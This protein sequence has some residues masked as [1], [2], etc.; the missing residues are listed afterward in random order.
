MLELCLRTPPPRRVDLEHDL[1]LLEAPQEAQLGACEGG[2][3]PRGWPSHQHWPPLLDSKRRAR[4]GR[5]AC[6]DPRRPRW[7]GATLHLSRYRRALERLG[8]PSARARGQARRPGLPLPRSPAGALH[9]F[10]GHP[11][12]RRRRPA[13]LLRVRRRGTLSAHGQQQDDDGH[14]A[15]EAL[16][17]GAPNPRTPPRVA[18]RDRRRP[19]GIRSPSQGGR[20]GLRDGREPPDRDRPAVD[21]RGD[22]ERPALH[23]GHHRAAEGRAPRAFERSRPV[24]DDQG[25]AGPPG[26]R[27]LLVHR[28]PRLGHGHVL[29]DHRPVDAGSDTTRRRRRLLRGTLVQGPGAAQGHLP[30]PRNRC[31]PGGRG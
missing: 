4:S 27:R 25:R 8:R 20:D 15:E 18:E 1:R 17:Q 21:I 11:Q 26:R 9:R 31:S 12:A 6:P 16:R 23:F 5:Q 28:R 19:R 3:R 29:R 13:S 7:R 22:T 14:H 30:P 24:P 10:R 2:A